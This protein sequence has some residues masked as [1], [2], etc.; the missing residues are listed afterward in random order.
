MDKFV[1]AL[2]ELEN[3]HED[4]GDSPSEWLETTARV[5]PDKLNAAEQRLKFALPEEHKQ[6]LQDYGAWTY[7]DSFCVSVDDLERA[8]KQML[9]IW[10]SPASEF[11]SLSAKTKA[12]YQASS[13]LYVEVG[14]GYGALIYHPLPSGNEYY[15]IHQDN[16]DKPSRLD[17]SQGK[18]RDYSSTMRWLIANQILPAY[19]DAFPDFIF[20]D[21]S[22]ATPLPYQLRLEFPAPKKMDAWLN[23]EWSQ[24][25]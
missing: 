16:L 20:I 15:W 9:A 1:K 11:A 5:S 7:S 25:E 14:D 13:M 22:S 2:A 6:L 12:L 17:D 21:R 4:R 19:E 10:G 18:P 3:Q 8:D 23:V 24:F